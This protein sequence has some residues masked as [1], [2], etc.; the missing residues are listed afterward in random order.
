[1]ADYIKLVQ[2]YDECRKQANRV[3]EIRA[4]HIFSGDYTDNVEFYDTVV[5]V[6]AHYWRCGESDSISFSFPSEHLWKSDEELDQLFAAEKIA[7]DK[8]HEEEKQAKGKA[9]KERQEVFKEGQL[10][11]LLQEFAARQKPLPPE[12]Q[13]I[14]RDNYWYLI[15]GEK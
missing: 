7:L 15:T 10:V 12:F 5:D 1:M 13:K 9:E 6:E 11:Q 2:D 8:K 14:I 3:I 4:K